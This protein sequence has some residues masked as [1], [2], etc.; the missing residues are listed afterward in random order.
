MIK[1]I[2]LVLPELETRLSGG[3]GGPRDGKTINQISIINKTLTSFGKGQ[4]C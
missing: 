3:A 2:D 4:P 1:D